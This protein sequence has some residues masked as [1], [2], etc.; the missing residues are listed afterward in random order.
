M[1]DQPAAGKTQTRTQHVYVPHGRARLPKLGPY[2][3]EL[4]GRLDFTLEMSNTQMRAAHT[5]TV[6]G[7][8][9]LVLN[10]LLLAGVYYLLVFILAGSRTADFGQIT[11]GLFFFY[12][13]SGAIQTSA[14]SVT[15]GGKLILNQ[16]FPKLSLPISMVYM[17]FRR[18]LPTLIVYGVIHLIVGRPITWQLLWLPLIM[19]IALAFTLGLGSLV[20]AA[21]VYFRDVAQFLPYIVRIWLYISPVLWTSEMLA[22]RLGKHGYLM[23]IA[24]ANPLFSILGMWGDALTGVPLNPQYLGIGAA[25]GVG[26]LVIGCWFFI[27]RER[28][29]AV[30]I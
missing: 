13:V 28:D 25:W 12:F 19:L 4:W 11:S 14:G 1:A 26:A 17:S 24:Q 7:Q 2:F 30:R 6:L 20:A 27:S 15:G 21:Q 8:L 9:W 10:P 23:A 5:N 18:F 29:F 3:R 16:A 22:Q